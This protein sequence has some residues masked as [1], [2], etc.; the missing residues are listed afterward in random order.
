MNET[1]EIRYRC[2]A[3]DRDIVNRA[4]ETCLYCGE[5]IP[6]ALLFSATEMEAIETAHQDKMRALEETRKRKRRNKTGGGGG[7]GGDSDG[8]GDLW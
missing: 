1:S 5:R 8:G 6:Q 7:S 4:V 2:P 3:C